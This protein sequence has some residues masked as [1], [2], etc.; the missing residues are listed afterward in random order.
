MYM[1]VTGARC[2]YDVI[3]L[4]KMAVLTGFFFFNFGTLIFNKH[5]G[6]HI[7]T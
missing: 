1:T 5:R 4:V 6:N 7:G 2:I 3:D